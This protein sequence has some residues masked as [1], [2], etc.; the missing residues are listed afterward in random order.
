MS[1]SE[2]GAG[3][4]Q[5]VD[6]GRVPGVQ[7]DEPGRASGQSDEGNGGIVAAVVAENRELSAEVQRLRS[8]REQWLETQRRVME[9]LSCTSPER[10]IHD[11]RNV[12]NERELY[13]SLA[14]L[15]S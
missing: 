9:L 3:V 12:L 5:L 2:S 14:D 7:H 4:F 11:L 6:V 15:E 13:R 8:E 1:L 10:I